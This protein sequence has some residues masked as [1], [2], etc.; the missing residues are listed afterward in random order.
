MGLNEKSKAFFDPN[1]FQTPS[2]KKQKSKL[3]EE[4]IERESTE[5]I[6]GEM[7]IPLWFK[8]NRTEF[9]ELTGNICNK[10]D[11]NRFK[12]TISKRSYDLKNTKELWKKVT[13][14]KIR[15]IETKELYNELIRKDID[16]L[17]REKSN[18]IKKHNILNILNNVGSIF[19][20]VYLDY[21]DVHK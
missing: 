17:E 15:K 6:P 12:I 16:A 14:R 1:L 20:S 5:K 9:D 2:E 3:T 18:S 13:T 4:N 8:I 11:N 21:K 10:Q 7:Q 19:T